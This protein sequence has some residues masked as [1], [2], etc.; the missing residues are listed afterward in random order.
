MIIN[1]IV[2]K[3]KEKI[4]GEKYIIKKLKE[5]GATIG[6]NFRMNNSYLDPS[7][8]FLIEIGDNVTLS[9]STILAHDGSPQCFVHKSKVGR[10][11]I[12]NNVFVGYGSII[13]PGVHIGDN[14][15][16]GAGSVVV[17]DIP[18]NVVAAGNPCKVIT[19]VETFK[20]KHENAMKTH[21]VFNTYHLYKSA[22][23]KKLEREALR[24]TYGYDE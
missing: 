10:V 3:C 12:G 21:P 5:K 2:E 9:Y 11:V 13:L 22:E 7:F 8:L 20:M 17:Q 16:I 4:W 6:N 19:D 14:V 18:C 15:V 23:E 24:D 1:K